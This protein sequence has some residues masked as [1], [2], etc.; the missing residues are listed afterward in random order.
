MAEEIVSPLL[1]LIKDQG[2][3]DDLQYEEVLGE[4]KRTGNSV[5]QILQDFSIMDADAILQAQANY[6]GAEVMSL[7]DKDI[8]PQLIKM[9][10]AS[11]ARMYRCLPVNQNNGALQVAFEDALNPT[12]IDEVR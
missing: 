8:S 2:L 10:P 12:R 4:H 1:A 5:F 6:L 9:L 3:I 11:A 7:R